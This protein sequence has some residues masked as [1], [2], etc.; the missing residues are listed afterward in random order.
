MTWF[1]LIALALV[2]IALLWIVPPLLRG[3]V[4]AGSVGSA[5]S[6]IAI[7][8][9]Q[10]AD[11]ERDVISGTLSRQHYALARQDLERRALEDTRGTEDGGAASAGMGGRGTALLLALAIPV[12]AA[13]LYLLLGN[14]D[15]LSPDAAAAPEHKI[16]AQE[17]DAMVAG[18]AAR[19]ETQPD[20]SNGWSLLA[21]SYVA[22]QRFP[23]AVRAY[24]RAAALLK[25]DA[26]L[27]ADYADALAVTQ[28]NR[29][30]GKP[31]QLIEQALRAD[32]NQWKALAM[33]GSAAFARKDYQQAVF[34]WEKLTKRTDLNPEIA[35]SIESSIADARQL[36]KLKPGTVAKAAPPADV[37]VQGSVKLSP[38][39]AARA[40]PS[41]TVFIFARAAQGPR[42]PLAIIRR[43]VKD[44]PFNFRLDDSQ[45]MAPEMKLSNFGEVVIGARISKSA[46]AVPQSGDLQGASPKVKLGASN[47][48]IVIDSVV[49]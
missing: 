19:L 41:D 29:I 18:L 17:V 8:R 5:A 16:S 21:R 32:P 3:K 6:N 26:N 49:P 33:T 24:E 42:M 20:D 27:L 48:A 44:L 2:A 36:G 10:V 46:N 38:G 13:L 34:Y 39:L 45:A 47:V 37:S 15:A 31:M 12:S 11:L 4:A 25:D 35:R 30:E 1:L 22:M 28:G 9:D 40:D 43:Q 14:P 7:L 23:D